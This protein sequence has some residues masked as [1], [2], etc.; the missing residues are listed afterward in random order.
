MPSLT[1]EASGFGA[2]TRELDG[3]PNLLQAV[4]GERAHALGEGQPVLLLETNVD[5]ATGEVLAHTVSALLAAGAHDAWITPIVMKSGRPAHTVSLLADVALADQL[6]A[7]LSTET[8][9]LG[10][11]GER[12]ERWPASRLVDQV[13]VDGFPIRVKVSPGRVKVEQADA[14]RVAGRTGRPL[15]E[16]LLRAEVTWL[17]QHPEHHE[18]P[19]ERAP[20]GGPDRG[21]GPAPRHVHPHAHDDHGDHRHQHEGSSQGPDRGP[22]PSHEEPP[23]D[24]AS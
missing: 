10:I 9:T 4:L 18:R 13:A 8:G 5:D 14:A 16:V 23:A 3:R 11:R 12:L 15:R 6:A 20:L 22:R 2:G 24:P 21:E 19:A 1:I 17:D 7:V